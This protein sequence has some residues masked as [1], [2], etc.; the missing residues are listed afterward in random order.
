[1]RTKAVVI[2]T[3]GYTPQQLHP[4]CG[5]TCCRCCR[6]SSSRAAHAGGNLRHQFRHG[7]VLTDTRRLLYYWRRLPDDRIMF[8]GRG[9]ITDSPGRNSRQ[10]DYLLSELRSKIPRARERDR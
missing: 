10:A 1:L 9:L 7:H 6:K 4:A 3:N 2:A 5:R 8:G